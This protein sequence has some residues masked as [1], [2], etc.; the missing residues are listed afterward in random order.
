MLAVCG[1]AGAAEALY[2]MLTGPNAFL[3][4]ALFPQT[5]I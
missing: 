5:V 4:V 1:S 2:G 3:V